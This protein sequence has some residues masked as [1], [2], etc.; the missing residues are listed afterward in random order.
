M[1][2]IYSN[3]SVALGTGDYENLKHKPAI[4]GVELTENTT[5]E[6]LGLGTVFN[7]KGQVATVEDLP[8]SGV[9]VGD[10][11]NVLDTG[12]N[13][14]WNGTSWDKLTGDLYVT[15]NQGAENTG[16][17]LKVDANGNVTPE[18]VITTIIK[19]W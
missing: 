1:S 15:I 3:N 17:T 12:E 6:E 10:T 7:Y 5:L 4:G 8:T 2:L 14:T 13:Y 9:N 19:E 16:K 11:Y 18:K